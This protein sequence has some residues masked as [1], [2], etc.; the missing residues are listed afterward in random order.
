[1][2]AVNRGFRL[3]L[4][5]VFLFTNQPFPIPGFRDN[6]R[7]IVIYMTDQGSHIAGDGRLGGIFTPNDGE[8]HTGTDHPGHYTKSLHMD[9]PSIEQVSTLRVWTWTI[10]LLNR[11][12][13]QE[14]GHGLSLY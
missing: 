3:K 8:C 5:G 14:S 12:V 7:K 2:F 10:P 4:I 1:M 11:S 13:H 9:Y 6:S